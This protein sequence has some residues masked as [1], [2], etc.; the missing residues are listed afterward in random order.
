AVYVVSFLSGEPPGAVLSGFTVRNSISGGIRIDFGSSPT[1]V[2]NV[3]KENTGCLDGVGILMCCSSSLIAGNAILNN[4]QVGCSGGEGGGLR[5]SGDCTGARILD[6]LIANNHH[7]SGGGLALSSAGSPLIQGNVLSGNTAS[8]FSGGIGWFNS[9]P[10]LIQ[11]LFVGNTA[12]NGGGGIAFSGVPAAG[13]TL[14]ANNT[15]VGNSCP[16]GSSL[17]GLD[18]MPASVLIRN[19][20]FSGPPG[21]ISVFA[22]TYT[23]GTSFRNNDV[24]GPGSTLY[25]GGMP[26]QTAL[27]GNFSANPLFVNPSQGDYHLQ[28][29][30]P[31]IDAGLNTIAPLPFADP[32]GDT[33]IQDGDENGSA[34]IDVGRD[35]YA[36]ADRFG[37]GCRGTFG[38]IPRLGI[39]GPPAIGN[40]SFAVALSGAPGGTTSVLVVGVSLPPSP[41]NLAALGLPACSLF[42]SPDIC[43]VAPTPG[44]GLVDGNLT[45]SLPIPNDPAFLGLHL[46][47]QSHAADSPGPIVPAALSP[48]IDVA[49][50]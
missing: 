47:F 3:V 24:F 33:R 11:N 7:S 20:I 16:S 43:V 31:C 36:A 34:A 17:L 19:N 8:L 9:T 29:S 6:N 35:E 1:L 23:G 45:T 2:G 28:A 21:Q 50:L 41:I 27:N 39:A 26:S 38:L 22:P 4:T 12:N 32:D 10:R 18:G 46:Y 40:G 5:M 48:A 44:T 14:V 30:S 49:V 37:L 25:G 13:S 42:V 15:V